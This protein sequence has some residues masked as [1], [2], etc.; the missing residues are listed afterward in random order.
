MSDLDRGTNNLIRNRYIGKIDL[1][2]LYT[3]CW[4]SK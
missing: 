4:I 1:W 3:D 2:I